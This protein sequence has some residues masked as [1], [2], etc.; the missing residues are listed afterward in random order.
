MKP[1]NIMSTTTTISGMANLREDE[2]GPDSIARQSCYQRD[3]RSW[4]SDTRR[5]PKN[6]PLPERPLRVACRPSGFASRASESG[7]SANGHQPPVTPAKA[8]SEEW[9][10]I[11]ELRLLAIV[12][13]V[14]TLGNRRR[15]TLEERPD[16]APTFQ[17]RSL[18]KRQSLGS[19]LSPFKLDPYRLKPDCFIRALVSLLPMNLLHSALSFARRPLLRRDPWA[20]N[21][22]RVIHRTRSRPRRPLPIPV[23][24]AHSNFL[25]A[26][27]AFAT[28]CRRPFQCDQSGPKIAACG[29]YSQL[30]V[31]RLSASAKDAPKTRPAAIGH[32]PAFL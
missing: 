5:R 32:S 20:L 23:K 9:K 6:L 24:V 31:C 16:F 3:R 10:R 19:S 1:P 18:P 11:F 30:I 14:F 15:L 28:F 17:T 4:P 2:S 8:V 25:D 21:S 26:G 13:L 22:L 7:P 29:Q 27:L 12:S